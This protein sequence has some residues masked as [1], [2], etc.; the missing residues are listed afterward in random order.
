MR[1]VAA[2]VVR[3]GIRGTTRREAVP[4][5]PPVW[6]QYGRGRAAVRGAAV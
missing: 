3:L 6:S 2:G 1:P 5:F 4:P